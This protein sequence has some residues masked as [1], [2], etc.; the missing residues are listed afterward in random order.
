MD[1]LRKIII[2]SLRISGWLFEEWTP[3]LLNVVQLWCGWCGLP[4]RKN[5]RGGKMSTWNKDRRNGKTNKWL[6]LIKLIIIYYNYN[7]HWERKLL[8]FSLAN[9][10]LATPLPPNK[11][12]CGNT[13]SLHL[14]RNSSPVTGLEWHRGFQEVKVPRFHDNGTW[15]W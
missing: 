1:W 6:R 5:A 7:L 2:T 10:N 9:K 12:I 15:W 3:Y 13:I 8:S 14:K 11:Y 4:G